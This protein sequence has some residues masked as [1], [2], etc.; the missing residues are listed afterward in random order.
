MTES[1][2]D[3]RC[4]PVKLLSQDGHGHWA[5][6]TVSPLNLGVS[7]AWIQ[8]NTSVSIWEKKPNT[9]SHLHGTC[10]DVFLSFPP[11]QH[12]ITVTTK[13]QL[14][15]SAFALL[16]VLEAGGLNC[17][18]RCAQ[19]MWEYCIQECIWGIWALASCDICGRSWSQCPVEP[20]AFR[21]WIFFLK[22][23]VNISGFVNGSTVHALATQLCHCNKDDSRG[24]HV[25]EWVWICFN[26]TLF[27]CKQLMGHVGPVGHCR[28]VLWIQ[29]TISML[30]KLIQIQKDRVFSL[31]C[32]F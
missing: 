12:N 28:L 22:E 11:K 16:R 7:H 1:G 10:T 24:Q 3:L 32:G 2:H 30:D 13:K 19:V 14:T 23:L 29:L 21:G 17:T 9:P 25:N 20:I 15:S 4:E 18:G 6:D 8:P 5:S 27:L 26:K 31:K